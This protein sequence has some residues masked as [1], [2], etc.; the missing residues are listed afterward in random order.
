MKIEKYLS[1]NK[2]LQLMP[3]SKLNI[4][5]LTVYSYLLIVG[6]VFLALTKTIIE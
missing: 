1:E 2:L 4:I 5:I 3:Y 6:V